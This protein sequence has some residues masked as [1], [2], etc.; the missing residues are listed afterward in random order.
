L[1]G[2]GLV[3]AV[4]SK[5]TPKSAR[6]E[7]P[8]KKTQSKVQKSS[9]LFG[10]SPETKGGG[11]D[12]DPFS[13]KPKPKPVATA[14]APSKAVAAASKKPAKKNTDLFDD[15]EEEEDLF[16]PPKTKSEPSEPDIPPQKEPSP[17]VTR[18]K[19]VGGVSMF[20][21]ADLFSGTKG[22]KAESDKTSSIAKKQEELFSEWEGEW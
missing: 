19:P 1:G 7:E 8:G 14:S 17:V 6:K 5:T 11:S 22:E 21:G 13:I 4:P 12:D 2:G 3:K 20:G 10:S 16:G 15:S 18:K 9:P